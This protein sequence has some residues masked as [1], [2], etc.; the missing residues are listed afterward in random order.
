VAEI[1]YLT[2]DSIQEGVGASQVLSYVERLA[3][4]WKIDLVSF[5]KDFSSM[6]ASNSIT[7]EQFTWR[8]L[9]FG[10][11]GAVAGLNRIWR[12]RKLV[13]RKAVVHARSDFAAFAAIMAGSKRVIWD[14]RALT[15][16]Q[17]IAAKNKSR[18]SMEYIALR[19]I[20]SVCAKKSQKIIVITEK[21]RFF[22]QKRY[23][24][25]ASKFLHV[26]TCVDLQR[27]HIDQKLQ[28]EKGEGIKIAFIGTIGP[29][30]DIDLIATIIEELR[31]LRKVHFTVSL[32]KG[33]TELYSTL[34]YDTVLSLSHSE[35][36]KFIVS[37]DIG[38]SVWRQDMGVSLFSVA[39]TKNAEFLACGKPIIVNEN[40][41]DIGGWIRDTKTGVSTRSNDLKSAKQYAQEVINLIDEGESLSNRCRTLAEKYYSLEEAVWQISNVYESLLSN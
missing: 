32:S 25:P 13:N 36:P 20:E 39:A 1:Q 14:C 4:N 22:L 10:K 17:R 37:Q 12:L 16:D 38:L 30:Y 27:F 29:Q 8:P 34:K 31:K 7:K 24:I 15:P 5:E 6:A 33:S 2:L 21:A 3:K 18:Y 40:Q 26:S 41:G 9:P 35:M 11:F 28:K 19:L 23:G